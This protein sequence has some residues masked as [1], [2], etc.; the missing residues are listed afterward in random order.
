MGKGLHEKAREARAYERW[1]AA[2]PRRRE[3]GYLVYESKPGYPWKPGTV[4]RGARRFRLAK[5]GPGFIP[6]T[7]EYRLAL[8]SL[9]PT[10]TWFELVVAGNLREAVQRAD[11]KREQRAAGAG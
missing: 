7:P 10:V 11:A 1:V 8:D 6:D 4:H 9:P 5:G 3:W 2:A